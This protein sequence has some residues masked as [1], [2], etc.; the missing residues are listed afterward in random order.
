MA[1]RP[2]ISLDARHGGEYGTIRLRFEG[3]RGFAAT[4][5]AYSPSVSSLIRSDRTPSAVRH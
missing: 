4:V 3:R 1:S 2:D 5:L